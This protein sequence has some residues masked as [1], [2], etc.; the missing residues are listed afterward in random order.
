MPEDPATHIIAYHGWGFTAS[1]W[2]SIKKYLHGGVL[3]ESADRGYFSKPSNPDFNGSR[4]GNKVVFTHSFGL[5]WCENEVLEAADHLVIFSGYLN[6]HPSQQDEFR[7]S[8]LVLRQ[9]LSQFVKEPETVL[10]Q[11]YRNS[12]F[13]QQNDVS[14]PDSINHDLLLADLSKIDSDEHGKQRIF[15]SKSITILHGS[16]DLIVD[17][18]GARDM[19]HSLRYRSQYFEIMNAGH[20]LPVTHAEKSSEIINSLIKRNQK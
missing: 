2:D 11:F 14:I 6:F 20:A 7:R 19:Y 10:K 4:S 15:D 1:F 9:M 3:F 5:H 8:K 12:F 16:D 18:S 13:P 17:K